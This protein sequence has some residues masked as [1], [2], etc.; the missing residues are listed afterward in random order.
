MQFVSRLFSKGFFTT[1]I[2]SL[3]LGAFLFAP[4]QS[5]AEDVGDVERLKTFLYRDQIVTNLR[6]M[7]AQA[8]RRS[9]LDVKPWS[10]TFWPDL[11]GSVAHAYNERG[12]PGYILGWLTGLRYLS[13]RGSVHENWKNFTQATI[14]NLSPAEKYDLLIGDTDFT[15]TKAVMEMVFARKRKGIAGT[16]AGICHGWSPA[17]IQMERPEHAFTI[18]GALG[19]QIRFYPS[20]VKALMSFLWAKSYAQNHVKVEGW[21]CPYKADRNMT[22]KGRPLDPKCFDVNP[23]FFHMVTVNQIALNKRSFIV[24][25]SWQRPV[26][27]QP[28]HGFTYRYYNPYRSWYTE[29]MEEARVKIGFR[30]V[31]FPQF[32]SDRAKSIVG[33]EMVLH[34]TK[35]TF[36]DHN[37]TD[38]AANDM[39]DY[40]YLYYTL[41]LDDD[42]NIIGGE[43]AANAPSQDGGGTTGSENDLRGWKMVDHPDI[44]WSIPPD[45]KAYSI[46][47]ADIAHLKWDGN[48]PAPAAFIEA[49]KKASAV[50]ET[51]KDEGIGRPQPLAKVVDVLLERS[52]R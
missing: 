8:L 22:W 52:R 38:S 14:D 2:F 15:F 25:R 36:P 50:M 17:S 48:A 39:H 4:L 46:A 28:V 12:A 10:D 45:L 49:S 47:D 40:M 21:Q 6:E 30:G 1:T 20:D 51:G 31:D 19:H 5:R 33:V 16:Y 27:N 29:N 9:N 23:A 11:L 24:D 42:D 35:E 44:M 41:E 26:W 18:T 37:E 43:W 34:Y 32:R 7:D 13:G 3:L